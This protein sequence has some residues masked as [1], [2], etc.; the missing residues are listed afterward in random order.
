[1]GQKIEQ[2]DFQAGYGMELSLEFENV[3]KAD[4]SWAREIKVNWKK[5]EQ[6]ENVDRGTMDHFLK[7][8]LSYYL[9]YKYLTKK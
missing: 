6:F 7:D 1:M 3:G 2:I 5:Y 9:L 4:S 8:N